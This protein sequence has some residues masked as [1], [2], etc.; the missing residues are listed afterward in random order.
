MKRVTF[1]LALLSVAGA[2]PAPAASPFTLDSRWTLEFREAGTG[3]SVGRVA[4]TV[5]STEHTPDL[6]TGFGLVEGGAA[7]SVVAA[8]DRRDGTLSVTDLTPGGPAARDVRVCAFGAERPP[9]RSGL[10]V[11][12]PMARWFQTL[13]TLNQKLAVLRRTRPGLSNQAQLRAAAGI[14]AGG[15]ICTVRRASMK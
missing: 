10:T 5:V 4:F 14:T 15:A 13:T 8:M 1:L 7:Y 12:V 11:T 9:A 2:A 6:V 3:R